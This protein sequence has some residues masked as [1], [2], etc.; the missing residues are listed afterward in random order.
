M[1]RLSWRRCRGRASCTEKVCWQIPS[2]RVP[3]LQHPRLQHSDQTSG[4]SCGSYP[5]CRQQRTGS[6]MTSLKRI[7]TVRQANKCTAATIIS[8]QCKYGIW[9]TWKLTLNQYK[10]VEWS[11]LVLGLGLGLGLGF[12]NPN[13]TL[14]QPPRAN[15]WNSG[16]HM[17]FSGVGRFGDNKSN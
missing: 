12:P 16:N 10:I 7:R 14:T 2:C 9:Q 1:R 8:R 5:H 13:P 17:T 15:G 6:Q 3:S 11:L 4:F